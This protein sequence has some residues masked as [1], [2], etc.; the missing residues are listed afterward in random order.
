MGGENPMK[1]VKQ[2][3]LCILLITT[4]GCRAESAITS[5]ATPTIEI[6]PLPVDIGRIFPESGSTVSL[7]E[8]EQAAST[9]VEDPVRP[10]ICLVVHLVELVEPGDFLT[11]EEWAMRM[12]LIADDKT[13]LHPYATHLAY[14]QSGYLLEPDTHEVIGLIPE[15]SPL[16]VCYE[17][18]L[19]IGQHVAT[20][21]AEMTSGEQMRYTWPFTL[22]K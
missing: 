12:Y 6:H 7:S 15:G 20:F 18:Q 14:S 16:G 1:F 11:A 10:G 2:L 19:E 4:T 21:V 17:A 8:F 3:L 5:T 22:T 13:I 9:F